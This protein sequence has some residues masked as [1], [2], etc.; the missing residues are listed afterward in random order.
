MPFFFF[1]FSYNLQTYILYCLL[2]LKN[3]LRILNIGYPRLLIY[4]LWEYIIKCLE[5]FFFCLK[6]YISNMVKFKVSSSQRPCKKTNGKYMHQTGIS[7]E[8]TSEQIKKLILIILLI[9]DEEH[10][11]L[12]KINLINFKVIQIQ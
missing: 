9:N 7:N 1:T 2:T 12:F 8:V 11:T 3:V 4:F 10:D 5:Y 6:I